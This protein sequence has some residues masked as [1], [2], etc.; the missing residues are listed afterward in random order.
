MVTLYWC[1][2]SCCVCL[3][4]LECLIEALA[5]GNWDNALYTGYVAINGNRVVKTTADVYYRGFNLVQLDANSCSP[6]NILHFDTFDS[7]SESDA[8]ATY[9]NCLPL[10]TVL[11]GI[12]SDEASWSLNQNAKDALYAIGVNV[13][14]LQFRG[15]VSF[16]AQI[17]QPGTS[18]SLIGTLGGNNVEISV[19]VTGSL[20]Y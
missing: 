17:G 16:V 3:I 10:Y 5:W 9:I 14:G 1:I 18:V 11:I 4:C 19:N 15:K 2:C 7:T 6:T 13:A 8:M 12:T 20:I